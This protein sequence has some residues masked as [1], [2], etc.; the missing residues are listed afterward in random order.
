MEYCENK[1][2][3]RFSMV[4]HSLHGARTSK[5]A[6]TNPVK[7]YSSPSTTIIMTMMVVLLQGLAH[8]DGG[9][10]TAEFYFQPATFERILACSVM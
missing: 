8:D 4:L 6:H 10:G 7:L 9:E 3:S 5:T 1:L 2:A